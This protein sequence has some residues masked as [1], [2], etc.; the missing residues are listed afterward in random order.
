MAADTSA[1]EPLRIPLKR[2]N[3]GELSSE[4]EAARDWVAHLVRHEAGEKTAGFSIEWQEM[5]HRVLGKNK[6]PRAV[7]FHT[8]EDI[9]AYLGKKEES[10]R[11]KALFHEITGRF[12]ELYAPLLKNPL[13]VLDHEPVW[14]QL[15]AVVSWIKAHPA[16]GIYLRQLEIPGIDT[17]FMET[18]RDILTRLLTAVLEA[19]TVNPD[20]KGKNAFECRFG[21]RPKPARIRFRILDPALSIMGLTDLEVPEEQFRDLGVKPDTLFVVENEITGLSFPSFPKAMVIIGLGYG[22]SPLAHIPWIKELPIW[23]WG[24]LDTH[25][26]AMLD[27]I[28]HYFPETRSFLMDETTLLSHKAFWGTEPS[29]ASRDLPLLTDD[30][31]AVYQA[32]RENTHA[33]N[34]RLEQERIS[35]SL[36]LDFIRKIEPGRT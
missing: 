22:L 10:R 11:F 24:D 14:D 7:V 33:Q 27:Q 21:F 36:V 34:L 8:L 16:P 29:P 15:L 19:E 35:Y 20:A 25:G 9:V 30:E 28:R 12:P 17:K 32:L 5:N 4:F 1:F 2:P 31:A 23:Y 18:H 13:L 6:I 26:F 3:A